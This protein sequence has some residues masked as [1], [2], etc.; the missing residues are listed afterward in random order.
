MNISTV[1]LDGC[2][3]KLA[4]FENI[5][6]C[7]NSYQAIYNRVISLVKLRLYI[8]IEIIKLFLQANMVWNLR[9]STPD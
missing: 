4:E 3:R 8:Q 2:M 6:D 7:I 5:I 1:F 9:P